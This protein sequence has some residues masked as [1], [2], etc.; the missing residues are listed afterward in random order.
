MVKISQLQDGALWKEWGIV[1][2]KGRNGQEFFIFDS[3][4]QLA[5]LD[6]ANMTR[7][8]YVPWPQIGHL[9]I[10]GFMVKISSAEKVTHFLLEDIKD[11][12]G[13]FLYNYFF[14]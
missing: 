1:M 8:N 2:Y 4:I 11:E 9:T 3:S 10:A 12:L 7:P 5:L 6:P 13:A 14:A